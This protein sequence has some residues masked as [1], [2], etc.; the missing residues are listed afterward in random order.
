MFVSFWFCN[1]IG[2]ERELV[3]LLN[4]LTVSVLWLFLMVRGWPA[5]YDCGVSCPYLLAFFG[6]TR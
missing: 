1:Y 6:Y 3:A 2:G 4:F 5:A